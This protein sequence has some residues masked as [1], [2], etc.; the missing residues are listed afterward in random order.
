MSK[1]PEKK[2]E[3]S[4]V[5]DP[6]LA[7]RVKCLH[8][9]SFQSSSSSSDGLWPFSF[10]LSPV[11]E[12]L[13]THEEEFQI[14]SDGPNV[15]VLSLCL[16]CILTFSNLHLSFLLDLKYVINQFS[17]WMFWTQIILFWHNILYET[18]YQIIID[19]IWLVH[20]CMNHRI[21]RLKLLFIPSCSFLLL[22]PT[23][24]GLVVWS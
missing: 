17:S 3:S 7:G 15:K 13:V 11:F 21:K 9:L 1:E 20:I 16:T 23:E 4:L 22:F 10:N 18:K 12:E 6:P 8:N 24:H 19:D 14:I 5:E 2:F